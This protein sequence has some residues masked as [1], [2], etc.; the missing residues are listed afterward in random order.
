M[1]SYK[2]ERM[3]HINLKEV[4]AVEFNLK[5][6]AR[7]PQVMRLYIGKKFV[8]SGL[9]NMGTPHNNELNKNCKNIRDWCIQRDI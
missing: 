5:C 6:L 9:K 1:N 3:Y 7:K 2:L 8:K 4:I